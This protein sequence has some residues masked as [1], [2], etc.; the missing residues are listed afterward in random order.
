MVTLC[1]VTEIPDAPYIDVLATTNGH[2][3]CDRVLPLSIVNLML[4]CSN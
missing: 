4:L 1:V 2:R 3:I